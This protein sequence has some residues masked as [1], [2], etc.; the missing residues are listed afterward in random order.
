MQELRDIIRRFLVQNPNQRLG[1]LKGGSADVKMHPWFTNFDWAAFSKRQLKAPYIPQVSPVHTQ[2]WLLLPCK[3]VI[4][5]MPPRQVAYKMSLDLLATNSCKFQRDCLS[6]N[7]PGSQAGVNAFYGTA[8][9]WNNS[10]IGDLSGQVT[11]SLHES[12][13]EQSLR[14]RNSLCACL[15]K[16]G[17]RV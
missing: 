14:K 2:N 4:E 13:Q 12:H 10:A 17:C 7:Q 3:A 8:F 5:Q 11:F 15:G 6:S 16:A 1:A 9:T